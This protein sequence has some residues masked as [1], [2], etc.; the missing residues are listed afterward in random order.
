M[1]K[2]KLYLKTLLLALLIAS[3]TEEWDIPLDHETDLVGINNERSSIPTCDSYSLVNYLSSEPLVKIH[4]MSVGLIYEDNTQT[5]RNCSGTLISNPNNKLYLLT[6]AHCVVSKMLGDSYTQSFANEVSQDLLSNSD[7]ANRI[8]YLN[9][10]EFNNW[11]VRFDY[12][13]TDVNNGTISSG[14][15]VEGLNLLSFNNVTDM[16]LFEITG[17]LSPENK[18][19]LRLSGWS[20]TTSSSRAINI[21]HPDGTPKRVA[22]SNSGFTTFNQSHGIPDFEPYKN[23]SHYWYVNYSTGGVGHGS[24][25]SS[26]IDSDGK[27]VGFLTGGDD[28]YLVNG[29]N[30][31]VI[32][33]K[34]S[35]AWNWSA[36]SSSYPKRVL[37]PLL[38]PSNT[39]FSTID[40][41][42]PV[43]N[44]TAP[45]S[46]C[47]PTG[48]G[49]PGGPGGNYSLS[50]GE[51]V[52]NWSTYPN[53]TYKIFRKVNQAN[54]QL[55]ATISNP[56]T[57][58]WIDDL[59]RTWAGND[60][61]KYIIEY[62]N[63][64]NILTNTLTTNTMQAGPIAY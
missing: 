49:G 44:L 21:H 15:T 54:R 40:H 16:A 19:K 43:V 4:E 38:S 51:F 45:D 29:I 13:C 46:P 58:T 2:T 3:C 17:S 61:I 62:Y 10:T 14:F 9:Q 35:E 59:Y 8:S 23:R 24:S 53:R 32:F 11:S 34:L 41:Y 57:G 64:D 1:K 20:R 47:S 55:V 48:G 6:A 60:N 22:I 12:E 42:F 33:G 52:L 28:D 18:S 50:C 36:T 31:K 56:A 5:L 27:V 26:L 7:L 25:G 39:E 37:Q 30:D 63:P